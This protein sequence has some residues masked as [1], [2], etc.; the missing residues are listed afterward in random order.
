MRTLR[1]VTD[2]RLAGAQLAL[3]CPPECVIFLSGEL[4]TGKTTL[5]RGFLQGLGFQG[6]VRSPSYTLLESYLHATTL[7]LHFDLYRVEDPM[8]LEAI[9]IRDYTLQP[10]IWLIEWPDRG[11]HVDGSGLLPAP[12]L[13]GHLSQKGTTR[14]LQLNAYTNQGIQVLLSF[15]LR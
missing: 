14:Q 2:T 3:L 6:A 11:M 1:T 4:G 13:R 7:V 15:P 5:V 8:E 12:D 10:A 9:G